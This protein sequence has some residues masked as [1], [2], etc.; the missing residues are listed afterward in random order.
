[1]ATSVSPQKSPTAGDEI[2]D[3]SYTLWKL[4]Y[5]KVTGRLER[6]KRFT[7]VMSLFVFNLWLGKKTIIKGPVTS[8]NSLGWVVSTQD[9]HG[10]LFA[11]YWCEANTKINMVCD[12]LCCMS[13]VE[14]DRLYKLC[15]LRWIAPHD[16]SEK[17]CWQKLAVWLRSYLDHARNRGLC[18]YYPLLYY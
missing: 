11:P 12:Y 2:E 14:V 8:Y 10:P 17:M 13:L 7:Q 18:L 5:Y 4:S 6:G 16:M 1:M 3:L 9:S 15:C